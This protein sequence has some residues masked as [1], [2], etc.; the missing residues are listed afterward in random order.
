MSWYIWSRGGDMKPVSMILMSLFVVSCATTTKN[1]WSTSERK[2]D[3]FEE[4][5]K[6]NTFQSD[7]RDFVLFFTPVYM[8][9]F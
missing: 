6:S 9:S 5:R 1:K 7:E 8:K 2:K 4:S 3:T